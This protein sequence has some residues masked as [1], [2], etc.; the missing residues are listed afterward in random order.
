M[1]P[2]AADFNNDILSSNVL[3][4]LQS[5]TANSLFSPGGWSSANTPKYGQPTP[6]TPTVSTSFFFSDVASLR[7]SNNNKDGNPN[8]T[9]GSICISPLA[10]KQGN[11]YH[12]SPSV[13]AMLKDVFKSPEQQ[14]R[15]EAATGGSGLDAVLAAHDVMEDEDLS[16]L[17]QMVASNQTPKRRDDSMLQLPVISEATAAAVKQLQP[18]L[19]KRKTSSNEDDDN[20]FTPPA[21]GM[22]KTENSREIFVSKKA[23]PSQASYP[24]G[25][26]RVTVNTKTSKAESV[27]PPSAPTSQAQQ[28]QQSEHTPHQQPPHPHPGY[29]AHPGYYQYWGY[30]PPP[31]YGM[32]GVPPSQPQGDTKASPAADA[33]SDI[34]KPATPAPKPK[35]TLKAGGSASKTPGAA[36]AVSPTDAPKRNKNTPKKTKQKSPPPTAAELKKAAETIHGIA[37]G[38][39]D[40][41]AA[42]AAAILRGV[43]MRPSGKW[44][45]QLYF[46]GKSRYIGVFDSREK[47]ALAYEIAREKLKKI[48]GQTDPASIERQVNDARKAAF[49][50]V[51]EKFRSL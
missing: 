40:K 12:K 35:P 23:P 1:S 31:Y 28:S 18:K 32:Y 4:W 2:R 26:M 39:N 19:K 44:Q 37:A 17:L 46:C 33:K 50:G 16:V 9:K 15:F 27:E 3:A 42:L 24:Y 7:D 48:P 20:A 6:M 41:A 36:A 22:R 21:I 47:A 5:P 49:D 45:A 38:K 13:D 10:S 8:G 11:H 51:N 14:R 34:I 29:H 43:T 30:P 25:S